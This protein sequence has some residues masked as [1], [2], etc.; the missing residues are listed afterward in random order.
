MKSEWKGKGVEKG[1]ER[2]FGKESVGLEER[3]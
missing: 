3:T 2:V 1:V